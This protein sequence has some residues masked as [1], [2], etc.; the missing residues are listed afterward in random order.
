MVENVYVAIPAYNAAT[1]LPGVFGRMTPDVRRRITRFVAVDDGSTDDTY[2]V[3]RGLA[4]GG[5]P[6][7]VL[8][9][10]ANRGYGA[11]EKT[12][13]DFAVSAGADVLLLLH[14]DGQY[15]PELIPAMLAPF[16]RAEADLVQGSRMLEGGALAGGMPLYKFVANKSLTTLE[17]L[18]FR[19]RMAEYHSG[20]MAYLAGFLRTI[21]YHALSDSFDFD[22]EM[23]VMARVRK[24]RIREVPIPTIYADE[25]SHLNPVDY[26]LRV[27]R[28]M[29]R[30]LAR[31]YHRLDEGKE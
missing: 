16:N 4:D 25:T 23:I 5:E 21:P 27:L 8:R 11:A 3:L 26:G 10:D 22:L 18:V 2:A 9:H 30:Y 28:V 31:H 29:G 7:T 13:L 1:T 19:M 24:A 6:L 15:A 12:L 20:Y 17:N 14:A